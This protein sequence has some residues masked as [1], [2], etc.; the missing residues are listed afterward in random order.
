MVFKC[1]DLLNEQEVVL[2]LFANTHLANEIPSGIKEISA[3]A[4]LSE[5]DFTVK[6]IDCCTNGAKPFWYGVNHITSY[7]YMVMPMA[8][9]GTLLDLLMS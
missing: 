3:N 6:M 8:Q 2:K 5:S 4:E 7:I 9:Q 1:F